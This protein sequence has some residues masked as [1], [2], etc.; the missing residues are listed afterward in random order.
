MEKELSAQDIIF[1][2][3]WID[4]DF[5]TISWEGRYLEDFDQFWDSLF[6]PNSLAKDIFTKL[7]NLEG[8]LSEGP[9][10]TWTC[11]LKK[12][13]ASYLFIYKGLSILELSRV[14][15]A[16][17]SDT[18]TDLREFFVERFSYV[19]SVLSEKFNLGNILSENLNLTFSELSEL[20]DLDNQTIKGSVDQDVLNSLE[21]TL[22][23]EWKKMQVFFI[24]SEN[25]RAPE[26]KKKFPF[27][28]KNQLRFFQ[29]LAIL[30]IIG[31][32]LIFAVKLGNNWYE[33]YLEKKISLFEPNF[34]WLDKNLSFRG[35]KIE[36]SDVI[37]VS[38]DQLNELEKIESKN[39]FKDEVRVSRFEVESDVILTS[40][41]ALPKDFD[42]ANLEQSDYEEVK[43]GGFRNNRWGRRKA[44]RVLLTSVNPRKTKQRLIRLLGNYEVGQVDNVVPGTEIPGGIYFNLNVPGPSLKEFLFK[45]S[46]VEESVILESRTVVRGPAG[47]SHVFIWI[48]SI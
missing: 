18:A 48:K 14:M 29:E 33:N 22:Y 39:I 17:Y 35:D 31:G 25:I 44:Y 30:F 12:K 1:F 5:D 36:T 13:L 24:K 16:S 42:A 46:S 15:G 34:F 28:L 43:K 47:T 32:L 37:S 3:N 4:L 7:D 27:E 9:L 26:E 2:K 38:L 45:A 19:E 10:I 40:V 41:D 11:W 23:S 6:T 21:V 20:L 8:S